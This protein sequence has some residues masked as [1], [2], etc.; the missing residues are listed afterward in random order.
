MHTIWSHSVHICDLYLEYCECNQ[1]NRNYIS[2]ETSSSASSDDSSDMVE[3]LLA[4]PQS[5]SLASLYISLTDWKIKIKKN[6]RDQFSVIEIYK[7]LRL[8]QFANHGIF[9]L[10]IIGV[11]FTYRLTT[12][13][14]NIIWYNCLLFIVSVDFVFIVIQSVVVIGCTFSPQ[15]MFSGVFTFQGGVRSSEWNK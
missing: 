4:V 1:I 3:L 5:I 8:F 10:K 2:S 6:F 9:V 12:M 15:I 7:N 14:P 13:W 11:S